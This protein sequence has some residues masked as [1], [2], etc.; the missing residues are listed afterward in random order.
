MSLIGQLNILIFA[1]IVLVV[2]IFLALLIKKNIN[3]IIYD[4]SPAWFTSMF[5]VDFLTCQCLI[6]YNKSKT[7][8]WTLYVNSFSIILQHDRNYSWN[9]SFKFTTWPN[10]I[11]FFSLVVLFGAVLSWSIVTSVTWYLVMFCSCFVFSHW[12]TCTR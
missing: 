8:E 3:T 9:V 1:K 10:L 4:V 7:K 2:N 5:F 6:S 12:N 11:N